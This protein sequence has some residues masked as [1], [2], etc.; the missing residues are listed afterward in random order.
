MHDRVY[1]ASNT[2]S[3]SRL[4]IRQNRQ[5]YKVLMTQCAQTVP[6]FR[7]YENPEAH[8][9]V[10]EGDD[11][12]VHGRLHIRPASDAVPI[13]LLDVRRVIEEYVLLSFHSEPRL[14]VADRLHQIDLLGAPEQCPV[15]GQAS[16]HKHLRGSLV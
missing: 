11:R 16:A 4:F 8:G 7:P 15:R 2:P 3:E 14:E 1:G 13:G 9:A 5:A 10:F 12:D 6:D